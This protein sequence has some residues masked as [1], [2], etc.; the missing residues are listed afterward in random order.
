MARSFLL[1]GKV[2]RAG[3]VQLEKKRFSEDLTNVLKYPKRG[4]SKDR[5]RLFKVVPSA[6]ISSDTNTGFPERL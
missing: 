2:E 6:T 1:W 3:T 5:D 4:Y